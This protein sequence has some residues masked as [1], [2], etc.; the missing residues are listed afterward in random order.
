M[1]HDGVSGNDSPRIG[2]ASAA[3]DNYP[4]RQYSRPHLR[5]VLRVRNGIDGWDRG[6]EKAMADPRKKN[7]EMPF[8]GQRLV[9]GGF[10]PIMID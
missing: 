9:Y 7:L 3:A 10:A 8:D 1:G 5:I 2:R 4:K 6:W